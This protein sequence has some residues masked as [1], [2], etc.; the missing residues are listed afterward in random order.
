MIKSEPLAVSIWEEF[1]LE[2]K[3]STVALR[4]AEDMGGV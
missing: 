4:Q 2:L 3:R 1:G